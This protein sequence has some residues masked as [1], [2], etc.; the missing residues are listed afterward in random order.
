[1]SGVLRNSPGEDAALGSAWW[2]EDI[3]YWVHVVE[4]HDMRDL[5][6]A[7]CAFVCFDCVREI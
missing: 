3:Q 5:L 7:A 2:E 1:M 6:H 4:L